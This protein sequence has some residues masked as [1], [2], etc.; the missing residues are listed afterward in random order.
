MLSKA[1]IFSEAAV[2][3]KSLQIV[4]YRRSQL[5][6]HKSAEKRARQSLRRAA[7]NNQT[8]S[9]VKTVERRV[10]EAIQAKSKDIET[11][12][13]EYTSQIMK[14]VAKGAMKK[15]TASRKVGR[16]SKR[17]QSAQA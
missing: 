11:A 2:R 5:A 4:S 17:A 1:L 13:R 3:G 8:K 9:K 14:A 6:N 15:E 12:L 16:I 10:L 7:R